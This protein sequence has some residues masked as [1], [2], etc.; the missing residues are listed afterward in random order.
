[1][2]DDTWSFGLST[3]S[4]RSHQ[5]VLKSLSDLC[6]DFEEIEEEDDDDDLRTEY[7]CP[8]CT[9]DFDLVEL[10]FHVDVEHYLEAKSGVCPVCFTKVGVDMVDHIT[11]EH[12]TIYKSLQK[13]KLRKGE[14]HSNSTFLKKELEDGYWQALFSGSSSVVSSSNLAPDPLLSFLCN[15]PPAEKNESA[16]PS[17][18]NTV[19]VEEKNSDMKLL[20]RNDLLS[21]LS[22]EE[23]MEKARRSE[24]V[25]GLLLSTIFDDGQ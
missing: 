5:S 3:S 20:E 13:L 8:Y 12:R 6:I 21:P 23:H 14:S 4:S 10:C 9:D 16:Q 22:D 24:C 17:L 1:M 25:Q 7:Q 15:V 11:T 2:E 18:S 19:T